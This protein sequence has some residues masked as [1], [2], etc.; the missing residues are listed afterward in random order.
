MTR[1]SELLVS[2]AIVATATSTQPFHNLTGKAREVEAKIIIST[3]HML[4][5]PFLI[6]NQRFASNLEELALGIPVATE[7][8]EYKLFSLSETQAQ[9]SSIATQRD[10]SCRVRSKSRL[11]AL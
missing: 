1:L 5:Q 10:A 9:A 8:Y 7:N 3:I 6:E 2:V 11:P 4:Q